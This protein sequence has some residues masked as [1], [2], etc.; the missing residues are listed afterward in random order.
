MGRG[1]LKEYE[2]LGYSFL[3]EVRNRRSSKLLTGKAREHGKSKADSPTCRY[4]DLPTLL[5]FL[6]TLT[7]LKHRCSRTYILIKPCIDSKIP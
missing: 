1:D 6:F 3:R 7:L 2:L 5:F 4:S